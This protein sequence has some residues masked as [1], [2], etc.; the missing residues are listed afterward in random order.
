MVKAERQLMD[1]AENCRLARQGKMYYEGFW[2]IKLSP[3]IDWKTQYAAFDQV[4]TN[5][6][7]TIS[8]GDLAWLYQ[9]LVYGPGEDWKIDD[10]WFEDTG[11]KMGMYAMGIEEGG[12]TP[13]ETVMSDLDQGNHGS[14]RFTMAR[15]R[16][17]CPSQI[18]PMGHLNHK[19]APRKFVASQGLEERHS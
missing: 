4:D 15:F 10:N 8:T 1:F 13:F 6:D 17:I 16:Q 5:D 18:Q 14:Y 7:R 9:Q 19:P 2:S 3:T 12:E 11:L